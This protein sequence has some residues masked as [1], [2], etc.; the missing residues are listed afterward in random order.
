MTGLTMDGADLIIKTF[1]IQN[2][3]LVLSALTMESEKSEQKGFANL[4]IG[5]FGAVRNPIAH[6]P[7]STWAISEHDALDMLTMVS[8]MHR[9]LDIAKRVA[10]H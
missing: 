6:A 9:K 7:K 1:S 5:L 2:P 8:F 3:I 10:G 4:L